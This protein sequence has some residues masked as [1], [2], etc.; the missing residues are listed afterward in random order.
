VSSVRLVPTDEAAA[1]ED[2]HFARRR[3]SDHG[4][5]RIELLAELDLGVVQLAF[6]IRHAGIHCTVQKPPES[7]P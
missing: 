7:S 3:T 6:T 1:G 4:G 5:V 2:C